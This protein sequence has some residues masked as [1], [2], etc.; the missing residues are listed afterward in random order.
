MSTM[1]RGP[2]YGQ[3][4]AVTKSDGET[5]T[6]DTVACVDPLNIAVRVGNASFVFDLNAG[7]YISAGGMLELREP[8]DGPDHPDGPWADGW[9]DRSRGA[10]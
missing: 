10:A 3:T 1:I 4:V 6:H 2:Q 9:A 8:E 7:G 5:L